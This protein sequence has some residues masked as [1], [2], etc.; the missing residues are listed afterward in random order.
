VLERGQT[1]TP[2]P[3]VLPRSGGDL[4]P[5]TDGEMVLLAGLLFLAGSLLLLGRA[6]A[7][8]GRTG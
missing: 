5:D 7:R 4:L 1:P 2:S 6:G 3:A 8:G